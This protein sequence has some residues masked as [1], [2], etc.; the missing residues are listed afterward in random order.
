MAI[1]WLFVCDPIAIRWLFDCD[2][3]AI[4]FGY[5]IAIQLR[6]DA[7]QAAPYTA[8]GEGRYHRLFYDLDQVGGNGMMNHDHAYMRRIISHQLGNP[9]A[10]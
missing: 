9:Y 10:A 4:R 8:S 1:I 2:T 3:I 5:T 6:H 7:N